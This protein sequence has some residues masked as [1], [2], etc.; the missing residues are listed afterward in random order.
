MEDLA[1]TKLRLV[2]LGTVTG[3]K[4]DSRAII[5]DEK[6]KLEDLYQVGSE[7]QGAVISRISRG[8]VVLQVNG[9][10]EVLAIKDPENGDQDQGGAARMETKMP[11]MAPNAPSK[12]I[13]NKVPEAQPRRRISFRDPG[14]APPA[15]EK[16]GQPRAGRGTARKGRGATPSRR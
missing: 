16:A 10:E 13:E 7:V 8:K 5:R 2:L 14:S 1:E 4:G 11:S 3:D 12:E 9:R 15:A 6:T